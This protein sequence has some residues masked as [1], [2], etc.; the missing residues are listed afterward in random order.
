MCMGYGRLRGRGE[1]CSMKNRFGTLTP[2]PPPPGL[3][4]RRW[5]RKARAPV[6]TGDRGGVRG[7]EKT[8]APLYTGRQKF[9]CGSEGVQ[10][11]PTVRTAVQRWSV[12]GVTA[13]QCR[14]VHRAPRPCRA[15]IARPCPRCQSSSSIYIIIVITII[16]HNTIIFRGKEK[17]AYSRLLT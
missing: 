1:V 11:F 4:V 12:R 15:R 5:Q 16:I 9:A 3:Y 8:F 13:R 14:H 2:C 17:I 7:A 10:N 6:P